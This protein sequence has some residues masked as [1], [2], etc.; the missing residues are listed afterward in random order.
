[1][2]SWLWWRT[3]EIDRNKIAWLYEVVDEQERGIHDNR[4][5]IRKALQ[6]IESEHNP[7]PELD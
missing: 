7:T 3:K 4:N 2:R 5:L 1:M 6:S